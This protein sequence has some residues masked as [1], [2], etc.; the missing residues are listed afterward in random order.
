M[1]LVRINKPM[2]ELIGQY[3]FN[4]YDSYC[5]LSYNYTFR[6]YFWVLISTLLGILSI[7][8]TFYVFIE[9]VLKDFSLISLII[10]ILFG[11]ITFLT[12]GYSI[13]RLIETSK[14]IVVIDTENQIVKINLSLFNKINL[15][16]KEI[17]KL[18]YHLNTEMFH[19][20]DMEDDNSGK[21]RFWVE[22][23][24]I[25]KKNKKIKI[26]HINPMAFFDEGEYITK[27]EL[28]RIGKKVS[29]RLGKELGVKIKKINN[30]K[31]DNGKN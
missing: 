15:T 10:V 3:E 1:T 22:V 26:L 24:L 20:F 6:D 21:K 12:F 23:E 13:A 5:S 2:K 31:N 17:I 27:L 25:T 14:D 9:D 16:F 4:T 18:Q 19:G 8:L 7:I 11:F 29:E 30:V 28:I